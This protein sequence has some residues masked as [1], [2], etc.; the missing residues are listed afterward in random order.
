[1][2]VARLNTI[3][4]T[5][6][7]ATALSTSTTVS[8]FQKVGFCKNKGCFILDRQVSSYQKFVRLTV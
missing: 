5:T 8:H 4:A 1:M 6:N 2:G 3:F 7:N